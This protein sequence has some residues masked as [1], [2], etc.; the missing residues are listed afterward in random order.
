MFP[1]SAGVVTAYEESE[2][3][4]VSRSAAMAMV[5]H[6]TESVYRRY[7]LVD[8]IALEEADRKLAALGENS[9]AGATVVP[10]REPVRSQWE[11]RSSRAKGENA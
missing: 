5:G 10:L 1:K 7:A 11:K 6:Q 4:D 2:R 9:R 3:A 8:S